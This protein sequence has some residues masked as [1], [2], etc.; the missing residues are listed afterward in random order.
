MPDRL[1]KHAAFELSQCT[2][3]LMALVN[4]FPSGGFFR[5]IQSSFAVGTVSLLKRQHIYLQRNAAETQSGLRQRL[6]S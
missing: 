6:P 3:S 2:A 5:S 1:Q 4:S